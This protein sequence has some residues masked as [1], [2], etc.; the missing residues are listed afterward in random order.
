MSAR[1]RPAKG[2][3]L[4]VTLALLATAGIV[5][6]HSIHLAI[7][8][9][10]ATRSLAREQES[11]GHGIARLVASEAADPVLTHDMITLSEIVERATSIH[12]VAYCFVVQNGDVAASSFQGGTPAA[13]VALR[14]GGAQGPAVV[15]DRGDRYL[16]VEEPILGGEAGTVRVG[17]DM[18]SLQSTQ[19]ALAIP[20][21]L[22]ALG[23]I[24]S[25]AAVALLFGRTLAKPIDEIVAAADL[26]D[27]AGGSVRLVVPHGAREVAT[28]ADRFNGMMRR[29]SAAHEERER[30]RAQALAGAR[31]VALG[32][33]VA[34]VAHEVNNPL[35][36][37]KACVALLRGGR[38]ACAREEDLD[39]MDEAL[40]RLR[41]VVRRLLD[42]A[43]PRPLELE[44]A[45]L[46]QIAR[47]ASDLARLSLRQ[48]GIAID[49]IVEHSA[50]REPV[51]A[52]RKQIA[53]ALLNLLLNAAYFSKDGGRVRVKLRSRGAFRGVAI[54]DDGPGIPEEIRSRI[55]E[56]FFSTK[57]TSEG[58]G[59]GLAV[60]RAIVDR[61]NG[62]LEFAFPEGGGTV[63]TVWLPTADPDVSAGVARAG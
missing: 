48:R 41:D 3:R 13:L 62:A 40:D 16:D 46:V 21:G 24:V 47:E 37:L 25:G 39:L 17:I 50:A 52:D 23:L 57:P 60:T 34:G 8:A 7:A 29:L 58:T 12:G 15:A 1:A 31:L 9:R 30:V 53:Q 38:D 2:V 10:I 32:S 19:R 45:S 63:A 18:A 42:I 5:V 20:L 59:L 35:A 28:L 54:E 14:D 26:F 55:G 56:P 43:R 22:L 61:H 33:L 44:P 4:W 6:M 11:L 51:V 49:E 36:S 27:P